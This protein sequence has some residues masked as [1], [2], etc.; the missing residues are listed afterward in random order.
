MAPRS[1]EL[2]I[3]ALL[4]TKSMTCEAHNLPTSP[5]LGTYKRHVTLNTRRVRSAARDRLVSKRYKGRTC[6]YR[7]AVRSQTA[8]H[9]ILHAFLH[10]GQRN[11]LPKRPAC[12]VCNQVKSE[13]EHHLTALMPFGGTHNE[14]TAT[15]TTL[16][17]F[18]FGRKEALHLRFTQAY[19][20]R[21][22]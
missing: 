3:L 1:Y 7:M 18:R 10:I 12:V 4:Q 14:A 19:D 5:F 21:Q 16:V 9:V 6:L 22:T 20:V 2:K 11:D 13:L 8:D 17:P 15:L